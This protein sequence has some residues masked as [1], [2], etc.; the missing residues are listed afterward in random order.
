MAGA[1]VKHPHADNGLPFSIWWAV[2]EAVAV[3]LLVPALRLLGAI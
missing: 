1:N 3:A 2:A